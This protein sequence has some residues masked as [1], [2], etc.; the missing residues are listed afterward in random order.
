M[1]KAYES[2]KTA[3]LSRAER[4]EAVI[5]GLCDA[6]PASQVTGPDNHLRIQLGGIP[7][8]LMTIADRI[9]ERLDEQAGIPLPRI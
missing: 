4:R 5:Q 2:A 7:I 9:V 8:C 6:L 1:S 3:V